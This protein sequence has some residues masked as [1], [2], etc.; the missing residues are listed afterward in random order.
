[1]YQQADNES[2]LRR[3][4]NW[5]RRDVERT[6]PFA[7]PVHALIVA[8]FTLLGRDP[9]D[10][11]DRRVARYPGSRPAQPAADQIRDELAAGDAA[12]T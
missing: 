3:G 7:V 8:W 12:V 10:S 5:V 11:D 6:D 2:N 4:P 9:A 1:M